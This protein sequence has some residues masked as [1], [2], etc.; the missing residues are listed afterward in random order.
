MPEFYMIFAQNFMPEFYTIIGRK[1]FIPELGREGERTPSLPP[2]ASPVKVRTVPT[3]L[4][5]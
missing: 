5:W 2:S 1:I 4:E 3:I